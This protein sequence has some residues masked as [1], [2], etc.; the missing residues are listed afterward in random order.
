MLSKL[1]SIL[2][3]IVELRVELFSRKLQHILDKTIS[4]VTVT[5]DKH[6]LNLDKKNQKELEES[7]TIN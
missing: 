1:L 5:K 7:E 3:W 6:K 2:I 4:S